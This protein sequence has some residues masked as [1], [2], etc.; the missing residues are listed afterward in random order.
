MCITYVLVIKNKVSGGTIKNK[1]IGKQKEGK[2]LYRPKLLKIF[3]HMVI[4]VFRRLEFY[5]Y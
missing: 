1:I 4:T 2:T 3:I 5:S